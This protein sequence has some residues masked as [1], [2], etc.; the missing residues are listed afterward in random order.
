MTGHEVLVG[1]NGYGR[2]GRAFHRIALHD[3][4]IRVVAVNSRSK[5]DMLAHLLEYDSVYGRLNGNITVNETKLS[6]NGQTVHAYQEPTPATIPW[7]RQGVEVVIDATGKFK[8]RAS[9]DQHLRGS[10]QHVIVCCPPKDDRIPS[11]VVGVN[12]DRIPLAEQPV[13][14]NA[15]CTTNALAPMLSVLD[16]AFGLVFCSFRTIHALTDSQHLLDNAGEDPRR[17][18]AAMESIIPTSTGASSMIGPIFPHLLGKVH[19]LAYR[20]PTR[21][22]S[23]LDLCV[24][25]RSRPAAEEVNR[26]FIEAARGGLEGILGVT[27]KALVSI[28]FKGD[29]RSV[30][31]DLSLT[32]ACGDG[33]YTLAGWYDNEWGYCARL[34]DLVRCLVRA[35][36]APEVGS[37]ALSQREE[38]WPCAI[39]ATV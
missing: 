26:A 35:R 21:S 25:L 14:S 31:V 1:I 7:E 15:S 39:S 4:A 16:E 23:N 36:V 37:P 33:L 12:E 10:V 24:Q 20:V 6:I 3:P 28:D 29:P 5:A 18:R 27:D 9:L 13:L 22:V 34:A 30:I 2:V 38:T 11:V 19:G 17:S 32:S 8:D